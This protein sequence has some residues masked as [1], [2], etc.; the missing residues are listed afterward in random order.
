[1]LDLMPDKK[2][3]NIGTLIFM[4][5]ACVGISCLLYLFLVNDNWKYVQIPA[6][7]FAAIGFICLAYWPES[8]RF[9]AS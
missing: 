3:R 7:F 2:Q 9:Y 4:I 6:I 8:P 5:E 1:V